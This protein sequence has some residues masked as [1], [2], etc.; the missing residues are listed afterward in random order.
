MTEQPSQ[1][2]PMCSAALAQKP[3]T[4]HIDMSPIDLD[5][6][7]F[8]IYKCLIQMT[9]QYLDILK[10][11]LVNT[12]LAAL[13]ADSCM[14]IVQ[15]LAQIILDVVIPQVYRHRRTYGTFSPTVIC[16]TEDEIHAYLGDSIQQALANSL[17]LPVQTLG[18]TKVFTEL[19]VRHIS[20]TVNSVLALST[21]ASILKSRVPV[22]FVGGC[23]TLFPDLKD[24]VRK[25]ATILMAS[26]N[27]EEVWLRVN[28]QEA[29]SSQTTSIDN[30]NFLEVESPI[31]CFSTREGLKRFMKTYITRT[32]TVLKSRAH[33]PQRK[34]GMSSSNH[35]DVCIII[36]SNTHILPVEDS[37]AHGQSAM[38]SYSGLDVIPGA[39][40]DNDEAESLSETSPFNFVIVIGTTEDLV[41]DEADTITN[42][43]DELVQ[44]VLGGDQRGSAETDSCQESVNGELEVVYCSK[45]KEL[46]DRIFNLVMSGQDYQIPCLPAGMRMCDTVTYRKLRR[47]GVTNPGMVTQA[48]YMRTE[49]FVSRCAVQALF[50]STLNSLDSDILFGQYS[51]DSYM[52]SSGLDFVAVP[53]RAAG[54]CGIVRRVI[55]PPWHISNSTYD[56]IP[57]LSEPIQLQLASIVHI[58]LLTLLVG[59][60]LASIDIRD[61]E[62]ILEV[63]RKAV[64]QLQDTDPRLYDHFH[65]SFMGQ[66]YKD[67][68]QM[69]INDLLLEFGSVEVMQEAVRAR[70]PN[71]E[72]AFMRA[73]RKQLRFPTPP[74]PHGNAR[75][76]MTCSF[77]KKFKRLCCK[78]TSKKGNKT[79]TVSLPTCD[80]DNNKLQ[81]ELLKDQTEQPQHPLMSRIAPSNRCICSSLREMFSSIAR[82]LGRPFIAC[83]C[84]ESQESISTDGTVVSS[85]VLC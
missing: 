33:M 14:D 32:V 9:T 54:D 19:L 26:L 22:F 40:P 4:L 39:V 35:G 69:A 41:R 68:G 20:K 13:L 51:Q 11:N 57:E 48:L 42:I 34:S 27:R 10:D 55:P 43:A 77:F 12:E 71:F 8:A 66:S 16:L 83:C 73:L 84:L 7:C 25:I 59:K 78:K 64:V 5:E 1:D 3:D 28:T 46:T 63:V 29:Q 31:F 50:W 58:S 23:L 53:V 18:H 80:Q 85:I 6:V 60:M 65:A 62:M 2:Q 37:E 17:R 49:E 45:L 38:S 75:K 24:M 70:N 81:E 82:T 56:I 44:A 47:G 21:Q 52:L 76:T 74:V 36:G 30:C 15:S 79:P 67:I 61:G 72:E